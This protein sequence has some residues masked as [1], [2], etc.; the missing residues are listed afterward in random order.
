[1]QFASSPPSHVVLGG[2]EE[3]RSGSAVVQRESEQGAKDDSGQQSRN[4]GNNRPICPRLGDFLGLETFGAKTKRRGPGQLD[5]WPPQQGWKKLQEWLLGVTEQAKAL[6]PQAVWRSRTVVLGLV[7]QASIW[8]VV[9]LPGTMEE[10]NS[11]KHTDMDTHTHTHTHTLHIFAINIFIFQ[12][13][14]K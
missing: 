4:R 9:W 7:P 2:Y 8:M 14:K 13:I 6:P 5:D 12:N 10:H 11:H 3:R 1:M